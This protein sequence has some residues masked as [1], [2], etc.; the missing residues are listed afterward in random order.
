[1]STIK[2]QAGGVAEQSPYLAP[3]QEAAPALRRVTALAVAAAALL[4]VAKLWGYYRFFE[5]ALTFY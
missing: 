2:G 1:M 4:V 3:M 5:H